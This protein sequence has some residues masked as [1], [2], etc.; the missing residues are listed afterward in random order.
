MPADEPL[1]ID[2]P[3]AAS[4]LAGPANIRPD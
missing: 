4:Q 2:Y 3:G 1:F